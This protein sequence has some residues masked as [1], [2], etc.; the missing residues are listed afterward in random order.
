MELSMQ[1]ESAPSSHKVVW[2]H[3]SVSQQTLVMHQPEAL[4]YV[5]HKHLNPGLHHIGCVTAC[6]EVTSAT[7][8]GMAVIVRRMEIQHEPVDVTSRLFRF[9]D[10]QGSANPIPA[11]ILTDLRLLR[12]WFVLSLLHIAGGSCTP[13]ARPPLDQT[14]TQH[15]ATQKFT[16]T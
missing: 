12:I 11:G 10:Q 2:Q 8:A 9:E 16:L 15:Q 1:V 14:L 13:E 5:L 6:Y 3:A 7:A 4:T